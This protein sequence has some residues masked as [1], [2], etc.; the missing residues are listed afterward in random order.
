MGPLILTRRLGEAILV[1]SGWATR[2]F[3]HGIEGRKVKIGIEGPERALREE[4]LLTRL[5]KED[6]GQSD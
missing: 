5:P 3:I 4:L 1:G 2:I 6:D